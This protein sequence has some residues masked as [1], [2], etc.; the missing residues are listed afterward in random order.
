MCWQP[1][2]GT[3]VFH[4]DERTR[5]EFDGRMVRATRSRAQRQNRRNS[6]QLVGTTAEGIGLARAIARRCRR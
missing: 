2:G 3:I 4:A 1:P 6:A 5:A